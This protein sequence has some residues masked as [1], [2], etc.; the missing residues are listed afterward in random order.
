MDFSQPAQIA[1]K[2]NLVNNL[3]KLAKT[4]NTWLLSIMSKMVN[5]IIFY[6]ATKL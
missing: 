2:D 5:K 3:L 6:Q 1:P 4:T